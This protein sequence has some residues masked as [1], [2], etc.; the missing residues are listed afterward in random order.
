MGSVDSGS[1]YYY[2]YDIKEDLLSD[3][4]GNKF[5]V[6]QNIY[7]IPESILTNI[8]N[9]KIFPEPDKINDLFGYKIKHNSTELFFFYKHDNKPIVRL[10]EYDVSEKV[11]FNIKHITPIIIDKNILYKIK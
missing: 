5:S 11:N 10:Y 6:Y 7:S 2:S 9:S 3:K 4:L 1:G 8:L